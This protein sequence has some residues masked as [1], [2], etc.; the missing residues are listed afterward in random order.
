MNFSGGH[1]LQYCHLLTLQF[2]TTTVF[3]SLI[4]VQLLRESDFS[5][6][7]RCDVRADVG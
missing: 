2:T 3:S 1:P 7:R 6:Q 4:F 5:A